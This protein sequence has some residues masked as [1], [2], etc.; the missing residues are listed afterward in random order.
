[1]PSDVSDNIIQHDRTVARLL[2]FVAHRR[3]TLTVSFLVLAN[4]LNGFPDYSPDVSRRS[5]IP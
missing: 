2:D 5:K 3:A 1:M 4:F